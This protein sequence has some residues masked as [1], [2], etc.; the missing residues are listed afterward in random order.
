MK[1]RAKATSESTRKIAQ[2][3]L[4]AASS[5]AV[6]EALPSYQLTS[7]AIRLARRKGNN[8]MVL[9]QQLLQL[10]LKDRN[11]VGLNNEPFLL[12]DNSKFDKKKQLLSRTVVFAT[13]SDVAQLANCEHWYMDGTFATCPQ[14]F[15]QY[16]TIHGKN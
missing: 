5:S 4:R 8:Q 6:I 2:D 10:D 13:N 1:E 11:I 16:Y 7:K 12:Y 3:E 14:L 9:P 15:T